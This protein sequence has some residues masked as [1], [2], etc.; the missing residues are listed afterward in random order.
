MKVNR[1]LSFIGMM[2]DK[3]NEG[4]ITGA[5]TKNANDVVRLGAV[6]RQIDC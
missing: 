5:S 1:D 4:Q 6:A 3:T 2:Q